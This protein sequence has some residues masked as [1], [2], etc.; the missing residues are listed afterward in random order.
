MVPL[1]S[2]SLQP[3]TH[4]WRPGPGAPSQEVPSQ[5]C[6]FCAPKTAVFGPKRPRTPLKT[7]SGRETVATL[8]VRLDCPVTKSPFLPSSSMICPRK[9]PKNGL[10]VGCLCQT[11]PKPST[12]WATWL[13]IRF[14]GHLVHTQPPTFCGLQALDSPNETP[15]PL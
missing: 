14:R 10:N 6:A 13:K 8:H 5:I 2:P 15:R 12:S 7:A 11:S 3:K 1:P 9:R 4:R